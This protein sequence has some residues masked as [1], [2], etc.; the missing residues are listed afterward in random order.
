M[1]ACAWRIGIIETI[2]LRHGASLNGLFFS[3][4]RAV[5]PI[6]VGDQPV[7]A[8]VLHGILSPY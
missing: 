7:Q 5:E 8:V 6:H 2:P 1:K 3:Q 4:E